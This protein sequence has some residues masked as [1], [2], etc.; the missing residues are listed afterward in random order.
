MIT[1]SQAVAKE[2]EPFRLEC[3]SKGGSPDPTIQ[4]FRDSDDSSE[5]GRPLEGGELVLGG[6]RAVP[7]RNT[8]TL[9]SPR[10]EDDGS[11]YRCV[12]FNRAYPDEK[13]EA[14][15]RLTV[16]CKFTLFF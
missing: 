8:L 16:H 14:S 15:V 12:V 3:S 1:P 5:G 6:T 11:R 9:A 7:T 13:L 10:L 2:G 4:W